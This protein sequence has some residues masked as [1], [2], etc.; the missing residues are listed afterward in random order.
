M[1]D[2]NYDRL[3]GK[4]ITREDFEYEESRRCWNRA[5]EKYPLVIVYCYEEIDIINAISWAKLNEIPIRIRSGC[6]N[7]EGYSTGNDVLVIDISKMNNIYINEEKK[8]VKIQGGVRN[9]ELY[10]ALGE[11][12]YPF[13]GGGCPTV[14]VAAFTLGGGWGYSSRM[15]G[16]GCD[17]LIEVEVIDYNG[18]LIIANKNS[19]KDLFWAC[20]GGGG[21]N[22]GI[23]TSLTFNLSEKIKMATLINIDFP[24]IDLE[25]KIK[26][27]ETWQ[28]KYKDLDRRINL[29]MAIYNSKEKGKGIKFTGLFYG[30]KEECINILKP[31]KDISNNGKFNLEYDTVLEGNRK[32]QDSHPDY[33]MYKSTGRYIFKDYTIKEIKEII[34]IVNNKPEGSIYTAISFYGL[35]GAVKDIYKTETAFYYRDAKAIMGFQSVWEEQKYA[36]INR[37]WVNEKFKYIKTITTGSF[38][39]FPIAELN[40]YEKEYY[41]ENINKLKEVKRKYDP[42]NI[43]NF[44]QG[45]II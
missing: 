23:V 3:T 8:T 5:I 35:G 22:F 41:G 19:N 15:L 6:H 39:N 32:I 13:P 2:F 34:S 36:P 16:L 43:F 30:S 45:I 44:P 42:D 29:K 24:N 9:R 18:K 28:N 11:K 12:N 10:E 14:G 33:E 21:G 38:I 7:Y 26:I 1:I 17:N 4:I 25:E 20:R 40:E 31:F 27:I 37:K